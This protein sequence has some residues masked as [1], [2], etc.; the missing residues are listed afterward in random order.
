MTAFA[1][2]IARREQLKKCRRAADRAGREM[3]ET[4]RIMEDAWLSTMPA[5]R[6]KALRAYVPPG[7]YVN[8]RPPLEIEPIPRGSRDRILHGPK[9][10][11]TIVQSDP[12]PSYGKAY[13]GRRDEYRDVWEQPVHD[14]RPRVTINDDL[15]YLLP[16][17]GVEDAG[18]FS[19]AQIADPTFARRIRELRRKRHRAQLAG[20]RDESGRVTVPVPELSDVLRFYRPGHR[21]AP[22]LAH[23][24]LCR[25]CEPP[26]ASR[27]T[28]W[29]T[30]TPRELCGVKAPG[31]VT[32]GVVYWIHR[33]ITPARHGG[34]NRVSIHTAALRLLDRAALAKEMDCTATANEL[35]T[36]SRP[37]PYGRSDG[38]VLPDP[39]RLAR[40]AKFDPAFAE[41]GPGEYKPAHRIPP[42]W[43]H[44]PRVTLY[45]VRIA[46]DAAG[47]PRTWMRHRALAA[48][49]AAA[50][51]LEAAERETRR[52]D[53]ILRG[54]VWLPRA[55][56]VSVGSVTFDRARLSCSE[57]EQR[58][59][60]RGRADPW[61]RT[62]PA[63]GI[64]GTAPLP[65]RAPV[66]FM[67]PTS[68]EDT[69]TF[70]PT[71]FPLPPVEPYVPRV[72]VPDSGPARTN[73]SATAAQV[74]AE[75]L[76]VLSGTAQPPYATLAEWS[77]GMNAAESLAG[78][79]VLTAAP[80]FTNVHQLN[81]KKRAKPV[82]VVPALYIESA[83]VRSFFSS[84][85]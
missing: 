58:R 79:A 1:D 6:R 33:R 56:W 2:E 29:G 71:A 12:A 38:P 60:L 43:P 46:P 19:N 55:R 9:G 16:L 62:V 15:A 11:I 23:A 66:K 85:H 52:G 59:T 44:A 10:E 74:M 37:K 47:M 77:D 34:A 28:S 63:L 14:P 21:W 3:P 45:D 81:R 5:E 72:R 48:V 83:G 32:R 35:A 61:A 65:T 39:E 82:R 7:D 67:P 57:L 30:M 4:A 26:E 70:P 40:I 80:T 31:Y 49:H 8:P 27:L 84:G 69:F 24:V 36:P 20:H 51:A 42:P 78:L 68:D 25:L 53:E 64:P 22:R 41:A 18:P 50:G 75:A 54:G 17:L 73:E 13:T 76:R